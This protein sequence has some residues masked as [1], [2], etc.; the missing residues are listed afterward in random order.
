MVSLGG[1]LGY[2]RAGNSRLPLTTF[3]LLYESIYLSLVPPRALCPH[4]LYRPP[5]K[6]CTY[7]KDL[8]QF[9][10]FYS[11]LLQTSRAKYPC[12]GTFTPVTPS[13]HFRHLRLRHGPD[14]E[15]EMLSAQRRTKLDIMRVAWSVQ[16]T[17]QAGSQAV[18]EEPLHSRT[19]RMKESTYQ[20]ASTRLSILTKHRTS[21]SDCWK[22][23]ERNSRT[24][25]CWV[26]CNSRLFAIK[27]ESNETCHSCC[28]HPTFHHTCRATEDARS[29]PRPR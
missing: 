27:I 5:R 9:S 29:L 12:Y 19:A 24:A 10:P 21:I 16:S 13:E 23:R 8:R 26:D 1:S 4:S 2:P 18:V 7:C 3:T 6:T 20:Q 25:V 28:D 14:H 17:F 22:G 15:D 11:V